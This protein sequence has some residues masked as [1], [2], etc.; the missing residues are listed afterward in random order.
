MFDFLKKKTNNRYEVIV[1]ATSANLGPGFDALGISFE[2]FNRF[3][4][5]KSEKYEFVNVKEDYQNED[6]L[7]IVSAKETYK[8][9]KKKEIPF[10]LEIIENV[11]VSRGL[12]SSATCV[13]AGVIGAMLLSGAKLSDNEIINLATKIEGHPDNVVPA[14][15]GGLCGS[16]KNKDEI[17]HSSFDVSKYLI[18]T[19]LVPPFCMETKKAREVLPKT[20]DYRDAVYNISRVAL[21]PNAFESGD[22]DKLNILLSDKMHEPYRYP[23][24]KESEIFIDFA[25]KNKLPLCL[26]GSGSTLLLISKG[27]MVNALEKIK[28]EANWQYLTLKVAK[29]GTRWVE[30]DD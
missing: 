5:K 26:S 19:A 17:I 2:L 30:Y 14:Y 12:G 21:I 3:I 20:L 8:Y 24:I 4:F 27:E 16:V 15:F 28:V 23:L 10:V 7:V 6:N 1:P 22:L 9:L 29:K 25:K 13:L 18:F 11:P